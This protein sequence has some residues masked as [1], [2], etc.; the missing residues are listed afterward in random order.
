MLRSKDVVDI[1]AA[2]RTLEVGTGGMKSP[3]DISHFREARHLL[4]STF[5]QRAMEIEFERGRRT[6]MRH[7]NTSIIALS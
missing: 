7:Q 2:L 3:F 4:R 6:C 1:V 5:L